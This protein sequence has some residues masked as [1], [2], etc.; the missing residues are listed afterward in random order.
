MQSSVAI[1]VDENQTLLQGMDETDPLRTVRLVR[2]YSFSS[3]QNNILVS[4]HLT[5]KVTMVPTFVKEGNSYKLVP[6][7]RF[8]GTKEIQLTRIP[9]KDISIQ[10]ELS[11][12]S[13]EEPLQFSLFLENEIQCLTC[14]L[15]HEGGNTPGEYLYVSPFSIQS[16]LKVNRANKEHLYTCSLD[17]ELS[18]LREIAEHPCKNALERMLMFATSA[19]IHREEECLTS[20]YNY[21]ENRLLPHLSGTAIDDIAVL[22]ALDLIG[23]GKLDV[24][25]DQNLANRLTDII[26][27]HA[28]SKFSPKDSNQALVRHTLKNSKAIASFYEKLDYALFCRL[29]LKEDVQSQGYLFYQLI[30]SF[31]WFVVAFP[32]YGFRK[33]F[34]CDKNFYRLDNKDSFFQPVASRWFVFLSYVSLVLSVGSIVVYYT[35]RTCYVTQGGVQIW[36]PLVLSFFTLVFAHMNIGAIHPKFSIPHFTSIKLSHDKAQM[37]VLR[38]NQKNRVDD[39]TEH[40]PIDFNISWIKKYMNMSSGIKYFSCIVVVLLLL[41]APAIQVTLFE[42][43]LSYSSGGNI[44]KPCF[45]NKTETGILVYSANVVTTLWTTSVL[46]ICGLFYFRAYFMIKGILTKAQENDYNGENDSNE[47][48]VRK[49]ESLEYLLTLI[50][51][52]VGSINHSLAHM[53]MI[54]CIVLVLFVLA[55]FTLFYYIRFHHVLQ[56]SILGSIVYTVVLAVPSIV[57]LILIALINNMVVRNLLEILQDNQQSLINQIGRQQSLEMQQRNTTQP[58][59]EDT[60]SR[61]IR[62]RDYLHHQINLLRSHGQ[63]NTIKL[64]GFLPINLPLLIS[65]SLTIG[66]SVVAY[67]LSYLTSDV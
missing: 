17:V 42:V 4:E 20:L 62:A 63:I 44:S 60:I 2:V 23:M 22:T 5:M 48:D 38:Q 49:P 30:K 25:S 37:I 58:S 51:V 66:G 21:C 56:I 40:E 61:L 52:I 65:V 32:Y 6:K 26:V 39:E 36:V 28:K 14:V 64:F 18:K 54:G 15:I 13:A 57:I 43:E 9:P 29:E 34:R 8:C 27:T 31:L 16:T 46:V 19:I 55:F 33:I 24:S 53:I 41:I 45:M 7:S 3:T 1:N 67:L 11:H 10:A 47:F 35:L 59:T 50:R 12:I